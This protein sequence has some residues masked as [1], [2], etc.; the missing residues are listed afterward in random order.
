MDNLF[1]ISTTLISTNISKETVA[2]LSDN[3]KTFQSLLTA[4]NVIIKFG[5]NNMLFSPEPNGPTNKE[6]VEINLIAGFP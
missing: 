2:I 4:C 3:S 5:N 1:S 6:F